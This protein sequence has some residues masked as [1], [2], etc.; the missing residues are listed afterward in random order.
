MNVRCHLIFWPEGNF[1]TIYGVNSFK[2]SELTARIIYG[3]FYKNSSVKANIAL[4]SMNIQIIKNTPE[5]PAVCSY[6]PK[7]Q[8]CSPSPVF[9]IIK[10]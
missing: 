4:I 8:N 1:G 5:L 10:I 3:I 7:P 2:N 9:I 6:P